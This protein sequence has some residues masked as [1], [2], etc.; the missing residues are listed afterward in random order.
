MPGPSS[1]NI[2]TNRA[3]SDASLYFQELERRMLKRNP[4]PAQNR[5]INVYLFRDGLTTQKPMLER[6]S[7][8]ES[9]SQKR[10]QTHALHWQI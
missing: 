5:E 10:G 2:K 3:R 9:R 1:N 6:R 4:T 7:K 8:S